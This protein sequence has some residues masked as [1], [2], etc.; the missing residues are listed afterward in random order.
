MLPWLANWVLYLPFRFCVFTRFKRKCK[1]HSR[2]ISHNLSVMQIKNKYLMHFLKKSAKPFS[3][4]YVKFDV[5][6]R[7]VRLDWNYFEPASAPLKPWIETR[8]S[9]LQ[10]IPPGREQYTVSSPTH[11]LANICIFLYKYGYNV[12]LGLTFW[13]KWS[14][15]GKKI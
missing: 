4:F 5:R 1:R 11:G 6:R 15:K 14:L 12:L 7:S 3:Q 10:T 13:T 8:L 2:E 9:K